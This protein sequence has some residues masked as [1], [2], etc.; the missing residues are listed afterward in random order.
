MVWCR[1][2]VPGSTLRWADRLGVMLGSVKMRKH[3]VMSFLFVIDG[4]KVMSSFWCRACRLFCFLDAVSERLPCLSSGISGLYL[5]YKASIF[6]CASVAHSWG[7][8]HRLIRSL[9]QSEQL[10]YA[11][12]VC[13]LGVGGI[14]NLLEILIRSAIVSAS[15][16]SIRHLVVLLFDWVCSV[17]GW[18]HAGS[19]FIRCGASLIVLKVRWYLRPAFSILT[20]SLFWI[21]F[22]PLMCGFQ[23][24]RKVFVL[25][26]WFVPWGAAAS[27]RVSVIFAHVGR[28]VEG[29][30]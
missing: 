16:V 18:Y 26:L 20:V 13:G 29:M 11:E 23:V 24:C 28:F 15:W 19:C 17:P 1:R 4:S 6:F 2:A 7:F 12:G 9:T 14:R 22:L 3:S 25:A 27:I 5:G 30:R 8:L 21:V 10:Q